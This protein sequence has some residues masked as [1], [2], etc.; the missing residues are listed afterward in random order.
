MRFLLLPSI[1]S[2]ALLVALAV[3][4]SFGAHNEAATGAFLLLFAVLS[5]VS[6]IAFARAAR[7]AKA[8]KDQFLANISH[9]IRTPMNGVIG[10]AQLLLDTDLSREQ[11]EYARMVLSSAETLLRTINDVLD[12]SKIQAGKLEVDPAPFEL[13]GFLSDAMKPLIVQAS[14]KGLE[15]VVEVA[16]GVP[17]GIVADFA[18]LGQILVN[19]VSNGIKFTRRG[20]VV[21]S[22]ALRSSD[23]DR[24]VLRFSVAD[25]GIGIPA[26][27]QRAIFEA[28]AQAD[29]STT[30]HFGGTG[31]GLTISSRIVAV[32]G[33]RLELASEAGRGST[34]WFDLPVGVRPRKGPARAALRVLLAEDSPVNERLARSIL[35]KKGHA[36][37]PAYDG[38]EALA[39]CLT[40]KFDVVLMD[41]QMPEMDGLEVTAAIRRL[42]AAT[43]AHLPIVGVTAHAMKGDRDRCLAAGM[44]GYVSKPIRTEALFDAIDAAIE[45]RPQE[46]HAAAPVE[47]L[48]L[49]E[50]ALLAVVSRDWELVRELARVFREESPPRLEEMRTALEDGDCKA[51]RNA[52]HTLKGSAGSLCGQR[53]ADAALRVEQLADAGDLARAGEAFA[54]LAR[55]VARLQRALKEL[56]SKA[57]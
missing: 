50:Q 12:F 22:V 54:A 42:E 52:A 17:D 26:E 14:E 44:D 24:A 38:R 5:A 46:A 11:R 1:S 28:F 43:G 9:E 21:V 30:R 41:V 48:V 15:L 18:R 33:S 31:L 57:A 20:N 16:P 39:R 27:K 4:H 25:T 32:L 7:E 36:V 55:E 56:A 29:S 49:D 3:T 8:A 40:E 19:L 13:R 51:L 45:R 2:L 34:F 10:M 47:P 6:S 37:V 35:E 53:A 23:R